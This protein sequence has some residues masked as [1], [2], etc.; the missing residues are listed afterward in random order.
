VFPKGAAG[1]PITGMVPVLVKCWYV[2]DEAFVVQYSTDVL[3]LHSTR[4]GSAPSLITVQH[5]TIMLRDEC[6][7]QHCECA[8]SSTGGFIW[9][10]PIHPVSRQPLS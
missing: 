8:R 7:V 6:A 1:T 3:L 4:R 10:S 9:K 5:S 2:R